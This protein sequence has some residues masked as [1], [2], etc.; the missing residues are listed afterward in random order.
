M[1]NVQKIDSHKI[2][3]TRHSH[4][5]ELRFLD[6]VRTIRDWVE[7]KVRNFNILPTG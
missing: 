7:N 2:T 4:V 3:F 5:Q 6:E 1:D